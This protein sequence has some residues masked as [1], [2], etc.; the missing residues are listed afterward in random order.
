MEHFQSQLWLILGNYELVP[1]IKG[2]LVFAVFRILLDPYNLT[3]K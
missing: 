1:S 2:T 3:E